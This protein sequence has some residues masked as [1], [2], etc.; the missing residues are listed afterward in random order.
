MVKSL[1]ILDPTTR[2][3]YQVSGQELLVFLYALV[4]PLNLDVLSAV[5]EELMSEISNINNRY[6]IALC[7]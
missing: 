5:V 2:R 3:R 1:N 4:P 7:I 6:K